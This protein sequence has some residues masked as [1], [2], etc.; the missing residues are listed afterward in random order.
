MSIDH[1]RLISSER[2][3]QIFPHY[4]D[5]TGRFIVSDQLAFQYPDDETAIESG[6]DQEENDREI[7]LLLQSIT[8]CLQDGI[9]DA[10]ET[11]MPDLLVMLREAVHKVDAEVL[12]DV[13]WACWRHHSDHALVIQMEDGMR[14]M[15]SGQHAA[16][17]EVFTTLVDKDSIWVEAR[18][19]RATALFL[20]GNYESSLIDIEHVLSA[21]PSH[22]GALA[23]RGLVHMHQKDFEG[24]IAMFEAAIALNPWMA[25]AVTN[26]AQA[27]Q[28]LAES[29]AE[30][31]DD[32]A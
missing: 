24:A 31:R 4:C 21:E 26:L 30:S 13:I 11:L 8:R 2:L 29:G 23:G 10:K 19:K 17:V 18:N 27:K 6:R 7:Q 3:T 5:D 20:A 14:L 28:L 16:A 22:F 12:E 25:H 32:K 9:Q 1:E 15:E